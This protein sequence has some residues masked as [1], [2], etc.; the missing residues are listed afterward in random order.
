MDLTPIIKSAMDFGLED[1]DQKTSVPRTQPAENG[2]G[3]VKQ[4]GQALGADLETDPGFSYCDIYQRQIEYQEGRTEF[5]EKLD[6]RRA[7]YIAPRQQALNAYQEA[8]DQRGQT[9]PQ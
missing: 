2:G 5:V 9:P 1:T 8:L 3:G 7:N 6:H 4:C